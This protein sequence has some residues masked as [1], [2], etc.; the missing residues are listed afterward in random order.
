MPLNDWPVV[1][2]VPRRAKIKIGQELLCRVVVCRVSIQVQET[3]SCMLLE[4]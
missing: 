4:Y 2:N 3:L 1:E